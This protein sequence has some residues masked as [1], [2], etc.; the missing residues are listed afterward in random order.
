[1]PFIIR[2][3]ADETTLVKAT[4]NSFLKELLQPHSPVYG[5]L[6]FMSNFD[7][8]VFTSTLNVNE[9]AKLVLISSRRH[10]LQRCQK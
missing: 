1:M 8:C 5:C 7:A 2:P 6:N 10:R 3:F 9:E 4:I